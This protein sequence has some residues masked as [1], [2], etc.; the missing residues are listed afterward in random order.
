ML[1]SE[2]LLRLSDALPN[3]YPKSDGKP[4]GETSTHIRLLIESLLHLQRWFE[5][6]NTFVAGNM[7]LFYDKGNKRKH[8]SPD[9]FVVPGMICDDEPP[10][11]LLC[12]KIRLKPGVLPWEFLLVSIG[13]WYGRENVLHIL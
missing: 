11:Y 7:L 4:M 10:N 12:T 5:G 8:V 1:L 2:P 6:R 13:F 9:V 3:D